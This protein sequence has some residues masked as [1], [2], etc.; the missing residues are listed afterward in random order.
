[1]YN[2]FGSKATRR[3]KCISSQLFE[4]AYKLKLFWITY[5]YLFE[6]AAQE[7]EQRTT[8]QQPIMRQ[9]QNRLEVV[10]VQ[11][12]RR[13]TLTLSEMRSTNVR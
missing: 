13:L 11:F 4:Q 6:R 3:D 8:S 5:D 10:S 7:A 12:T 9:V 2:V 1:M